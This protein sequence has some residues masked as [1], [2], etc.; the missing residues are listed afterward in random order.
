MK[1][2][3]GP[4]HRRGVALVVV[5][6]VVLAVA[7]IASGAAFLGL[8]TTLIGRYH[9]RLSLLETAAD[10]ALEEGRS[11]LN[12]NPAMYP[13][14]GYVV[15]ENAITPTDASGSPITGVTRSTYVGPTGITS[16]QYGVFGRDRKSVV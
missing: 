12:A 2:N 10:A 5:L 6:L 7:A 9:S 3:P 1:R 16:G 8:N 14:T 11:A 15:Y 4:A 13:D